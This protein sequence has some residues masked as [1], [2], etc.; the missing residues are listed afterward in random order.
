MLQGRALQF[1]FKTLHLQQQSLPAGNTEVCV[2][3]VLAL[4]RLAGLFITFV[5]PQTYI[6]AKGAT[7]N[8]SNLQTRLH[9]SFLN[10]SA[11]I[12]G[13]PVEAADEALLSWQVQIGPKNYPEASPCSNLAESFSLLRAAVGTS[14]ES[15]RTSSIHEAGYRGNPFVIGVPLQ[16]VVGMPFSSVKYSLRRP[17]NCTCYAARWHGSAGW[18]NHGTYGHRNHHRTE[19]IWNSGPRLK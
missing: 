6:D 2:S 1:P 8:T 10:P 11:T 9:K 19:R 4:S 14:D 16:V 15:I 5:G 12:T 7:Q 3:L 18:Q 13:V 17:S